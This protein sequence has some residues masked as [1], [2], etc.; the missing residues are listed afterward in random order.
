[1][2]FSTGLIRGLLLVLAANSALAHHSF[3]MFDRTKE[4]V[5]EGTVREFQWTNPHVWIQ[6]I[7]ME[8]GNAV[9]YSIE[10]NN[11]NILS[12]NGWTRKSFTPG[13]AVT[14]TIH[15]MTDGRKG[16]QFMSAVFPDGRTLGEAAR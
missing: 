12:R 9:E 2:K 13:D 3:V 6:V 16:G 10:G 14:M 8:D 7:V 4:V 1:M 5:I 15:P 11:P